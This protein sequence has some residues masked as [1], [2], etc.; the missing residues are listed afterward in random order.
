MILLCIL[1][2]AALCSYFAATRAAFIIC[3]PLA[4]IALFFGIRAAAHFLASRSGENRRRLA[5]AIA[6]ALSPL[7][8]LFLRYVQY[9][10]FLKDIR[11]VLLPLALLGVLYLSSVLASRLRKLQGISLKPVFSDSSGSETP[12]QKKTTAALFLSAFVGYLFLASGLVFPPQPLTG[13]EPHY[14]LITK[15][16]L[17]D[18]DF[19]LDNNYKNQDYRMFYPGTLDV[20]GQPGRKGRGTLYS[21]HLPGLPV[22]LAPWFALGEHV[23]RFLSAELKN[24]AL[25]ARVFIFIARIPM[26]LLTA[27]LGV[28]AYLLALDMT[29]KRKSSLWAWLV[30]SF[31]APLVFYSQLIYPDVPAALIGLIAYRYFIQARRPRSSMSLGLVGVGLALLPWLGIKYSVLSIILFFLIVLSLFKAQGKIP[32]SILFLS[33]PVVLS[34]CFFALTLWNLYGNFSPYAIYGGA[35]PAKVHMSLVSRLADTVRFGLG[36]FFDQNYGLF[37]YSPACVLSI[38][39]LIIFW[40]KAKKE[41]LGLMG[42]FMAYMAVAAANQTWGGYCPPG[43]PLLAVLW[44]PFLF[45]AWA[46]GQDESGWRP[47]IAKTG[48]ALSCL[49]AWA[50]IRNPRILY[51]ESMKGIPSHPESGNHLLA[52]LGNPWV[53]FTSLFPRFSAKGMIPWPSFFFWLLVVLVAT[54]LFLAK[55]PFPKAAPA[56]LKLRTRLIPVFVLAFI[57]VILAFFNITLENPVAFV[58]EGYRLYFQDGNHYGREADGFWTKGRAQMRFLLR[59]ETRL[60]KIEISFSSAIATRT[61]IQI[62]PQKKSVRRDNSSDPSNTVSF[63]S[64]IGFRWKKGFLYEIQ[65]HEAKGFVPFELD[66]RNPDNRLLGVFVRIKTRTA[67]VSAGGRSGE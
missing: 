54:I 4:A 64:P 23:G 24:P 9:L 57:I 60:E 8:L 25:N 27:L 55:L 12:G 14:L 65:V 38:A 34:F 32:R 67:T 43:R 49:V 63:S 51:Y 44:I 35:I 37:L 53:D 2:A 45:I 16:L 6:V 46:L 59:S 5:R 3:F 42:I 33:A 36:Y 40:K 58:A 48:I 19:N 20:H 26:A 15:S 17:A 66:N 11:D 29:R 1:E 21:W 13:D 56:A 50:G 30:F 28:F 41:A 31:T 10:V 18:G 62:G 22:L 39:G 47:V 7:L 61:D 52:S